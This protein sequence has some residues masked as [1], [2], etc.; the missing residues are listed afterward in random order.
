MLSPESHTW[1]SGMS[2]TD[3]MWTP[4]P[5][6]SGGGTRRE[7]PAVATT[8]LTI[9]LPFCSGLRA[10]TTSPTSNPV[11]GAVLS[12]KQY[13]PE[14]VGLIVGIM[15]GPTHAVVQNTN[16]FMSLPPMTTCAQARLTLHARCHMCPQLCYLAGVVFRRHMRQPRSRLNSN[17][18]LYLS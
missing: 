10:R 2:T 4:S 6:S 17:N 9:N 15:L 12:T 7:L 1:P 13:V 11:N 16:S 8:R 5:E 3:S 18:E 14:P